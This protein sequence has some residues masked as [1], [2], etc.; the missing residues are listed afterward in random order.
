MRATCGSIE[1]EQSI[2]CYCT[3]QASVQVESRDIF[4]GQANSSPVHGDISLHVR[5]QAMVSAPSPTEAISV[6]ISRVVC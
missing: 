5:L 2:I 4:S 3:L 1:L 6:E